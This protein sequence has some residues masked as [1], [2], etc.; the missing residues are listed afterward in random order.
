APNVSRLRPHAGLPFVRLRRLDPFG[1]AGLIGGPTEIPASAGIEP[2]S[3]AGAAAGCARRHPLWR[4]ERSRRIGLHPSLIGC[5]LTAPP[6]FQGFI[7]IKFVWGAGL[8]IC[9]LFAALFALFTFIGLVD[10]FLYCPGT[11]CDEPLTITLI[12]AGVTAA[13]LGIAWLIYRYFRPE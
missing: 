12:S 11:Q 13:G 2:W 7:M 3:T 1:P 6:S 4:G 5:S 8:A 9:L 10:A